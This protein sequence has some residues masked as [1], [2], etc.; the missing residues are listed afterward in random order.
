MHFHQKVTNFE[1]SGSFSKGDNTCCDTG[2]RFFC[3]LSKRSLLERAQC[4]HHTYVKVLTICSAT[5]KTSEV[6]ILSYLQS[7]STKIDKFPETRC[8]C[9]EHR[10][11][12]QRVC[13]S[14]HQCMLYMD[15]SYTFSQ[16]Q[17]QRSYFQHV[18]IRPIPINALCTTFCNVHVYDLFSLPFVRGDGSIGKFQ[19]LRLVVYNQY[20]SRHH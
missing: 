2:P 8:H 13:N 19:I 12:Q 1:S 17:Y 3:V 10:K 9:K 14:L 4:L 6:G 7:N 20:K 5:V 18:L 15:F 11:I 16:Q